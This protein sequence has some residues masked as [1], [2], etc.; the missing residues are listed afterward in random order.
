[1][2]NPN[3]FGSIK[4]LSGNRYRPYAF[5][6]S[7][8]GKQKPLAYFRSYAEAINYQ[9]QYISSNPELTAIKEI[10]ITG[11][12]RQLW[13]KL[14][15][16]SARVVNIEG[17][18]TP[19]FG[20][21]YEL[22][23]PGHKE[24]NNVSKS[25]LCSYENA[26]KHCKS[27]KDMPIDQIK[28]NDLQAILDKLGEYKLS[29]STKKKVKNLMSLVFKYATAMDYVSKNY[30][31][32][33]KIGKNKPVRPHVPF[34]P[35]EINAIWQIR[36]YPG[37]DSILILLYT[38]MRVGEMLALKKENI[39]LSERYLRITKS[40]TFAGL[41]IIP[42]HSQIQ[43]LIEKRMASKSDFL[44]A[45]PCGH[46]YSY[47]AYTDLWERIMLK[48]NMKHTTHDCRHT[49]AT[50]LDAAGANDISKK[51]ILGHAVQNVTEIYTHKSLSELIKAIELLT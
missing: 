51:R 15:D 17:A 9:A 35:E 39:R 42:I 23:L 6:I 49:M 43:L 31:D 22:W 14:V 28:Y 25:T 4:R 11:Q 10:Y 38:G 26:L 24:R 21:M 8:G 46:P 13:Q 33:L 18:K 19:T 20:K 5:V 34:S 29:Y 44:I 32:L 12:N 48:T 47:T 40:K 27:I 50:R 2:R 3:G 1:M 30:V 36:D 45:N 41:R 16:V 37:A 7:Q